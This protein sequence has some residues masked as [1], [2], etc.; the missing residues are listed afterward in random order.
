MNLATLTL[1]A[2]AVPAASASVARTCAA[3]TPQLAAAGPTGAEGAAPVDALIR[4]WVDDE[5]PELAREVERL[6]AARV[7]QPDRLHAARLEVALV[8]ADLALHEFAHGETFARMFAGVELAPS[9][10][11]VRA[12]L[13]WMTQRGGDLDPLGAWS[14]VGPFDNDRGRGMDRPTGAEREPGL[15]RYKGKLRE[16]A[17]RVAPPLGPDGVAYL[18][19]LIHPEQQACVVARTWIYSDAP[20]EALLLLGASE[21]V[22]AW[23]N[24]ALCLRALGEHEFG[25]D[26]HCV[27]L[28]LSAGWNELALKVGAQDGA[29]AFCAR[30]VDPATGAPLSLR[31]SATPPEG[32]APRA[33]ALL[34][35]GGVSPPTVARP[36]AVAFYAG[37]TDVEA[38]VA[39]ALLLSDA[40]PTPRKE[41]PGAREA[42][43][44]L[45]AALASIEDPARVNDPRTKHA[46]P[47]ALLSA[48]V[49]DLMTARVSGALQVEED[50]NPWLQALRAACTR[51]GDRPLF[52]RSYADHARSGQG[53]TARALEL[54]DR[55]LAVVPTSVLCRRER[56]ELLTALGQDGLADLERE[57]L[58]A[59]PG[60]LEWPVACHAL[61]LG[62]PM[63]HPMRGRLRAVALADGDPVAERQRVLDERLARSSRDP[64]EVVAVLAQDLARDPWDVESRLLGATKLTALGGYEA[65]LALLDEAI[66]LCPEAPELHSGRARTLLAR[67]DRAAARSAL[68][69]A[70]EL[71]RS[72]ADEQRLLE[73]LR[74]DTTGD[75]LADRAEAQFHTRYQEPL[76]ALLARRANDA[77]IQ[78]PTAPREV[79]LT[80]TVVEVAPDGTAQR[81]QRVVERVLTEAGAKELDRRAFRAFPGMDEIR[82]LTADVRHADGVVE[83]ARTGRTGARGSFVLDLPPLVPGDVVDLEWRHDDLQPSIFGTYFGLDVAFTPD[84][85]LEV[86]ESQ[87]IVIARPGVA[88]SFHLAGEVSGTRDV[89]A[90]ERSL[91]DGSVQYT[92][93]SAPIV[94]RRAEPLE[95]P[96]AEWLPRVQASTYASWDEFGRWWWSLIREELAVSPEMREKVAELTADCATPL[97][98]LRAVYDFVVTDIRYNAWEFGINSYRPYSAP[99]IF[100][101]RFGDCKDKA[102]LMRALLSVVGIEAWP[103]IIR[104]EGRRFEEDHAA[105]LIA[106]FNH[107]IA[108]IPAQ[109]GLSEMFLDGTARLH[110][111]EVLPDSDR[112]ARVVIVRDDGVETVRIPFP[113]V[114]DNVMRERTVVDLRQDGAPQVTLWRA[115]SGRFDPRERHTFTGTDEARKDAVER[116][117]T[118]RFGALVGEPT[119]KHA[120]YEDLTQ[121]VEVTLSAG[122]ERVGREA[123]GG[124]ELPTTFDPMRLLSSLASESER[125]TD[126]LLDVPWMSE[127]EI[128]YEL[129]SGARARSLPAARSLGNEDLGFERTVEVQ[130][131]DGG[132]RVVVRERFELRTHR[133]PVGRYAAFRALSREIDEAQR[134]MIDVEVTR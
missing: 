108:Y 51:F 78:D 68:E 27:P 53:L 122:V 40:R 112:G 12:R 80:R 4:L 115:P 29:L 49:V 114:T 123:P 94:P 16:V 44:A 100:S 26:A 65:A 133:V 62:L 87:V 118:E 43:A 73:Y 129:P 84:T 105:A 103:V 91:A 106:H 37:Q 2:L 128:V 70:A 17:W 102:I 111:L 56:I 74:Q 10:A 54:I 47:S 72:N 89:A 134:E 15:A 93:S 107:C 11:P 31:S 13:A 101:R 52:M 120:E 67:G 30:L 71:D 79:L 57:R 59:D 98:R 21:E 130:S 63:E 66:E 83:R 64:R 116:V 121:P 32:A 7:Q 8:L 127:R 109:V 75:A 42:V 5:L 24:G 97:E 81:Y 28:A 92:W 95:P 117:L 39:S 22:V 14:F 82:V 125:T 126:L 90:T 36:G 119:A 46:D 86:R 6:L 50:I 20:S 96:T 34:G 41:R 35:D 60:L 25:P 132:A 131:A 38:L 23:W 85:R 88:L 9:E 58:L 77:P 1:V 19:R 69:R 104:S 76:E 33:L 99:V 18:G 61:S 45:T 124:L 113:A 48:T 55:A 3:T 110:P